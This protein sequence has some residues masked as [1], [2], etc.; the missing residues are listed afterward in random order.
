MP[1]WTL[2][3]VLLTIGVFF[4]LLAVVLASINIDNPYAD[5]QS[6]ILSMIID[7]MIP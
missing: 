6:S 2:A 4:A 1:K 7:W 5:T 3:G